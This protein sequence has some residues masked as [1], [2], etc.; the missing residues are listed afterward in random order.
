M[1]GLGTITYSNFLYLDL[2]Y[3]NDWSSTL[4]AESNSYNYY[5]GNMSLIFTELFAINP[6]ILSLGKLRGSY[7]RVGNDTGPYQTQNYYSVWQSQWPYPA[8]YMSS[9]LAFSDFKP[10][11]TNSWE[12]G[13]N[14]G[15]LKNRINVDFAYYNSLSENQ[16]MDVKL[17]PSSGFDNIKQNAGAIRNH[18]FE[19]LITATPVTGQKG[20]AWD[21][22]LNVSKNYSMVESLAEGEDRKVLATAINGMV[23]VEVRPGEPFGSIYGRD[24]A[25]DESGN[26]LIN[27]EG[28]AIPGDIVNLGDI[29]PDLIGGLANHFSYKGLVLS[30]LIDFQLGGRILLPRIAIQEPDGNVRGV[31]KGQG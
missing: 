22:S 25:R 14:L 21:L 18:G 17:A 2:T 7:A 11:I 15:F 10:E 6:S 5:S 16:I 23:L 4:P 13:T 24:Y 19:A 3:R 20:F 30:F 31:L 26:K 27:D 12:L 8:G 9:R 1:Y 28:K 29:N